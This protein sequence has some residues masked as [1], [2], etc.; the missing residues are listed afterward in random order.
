[1]ALRILH[2]FPPLQL[3]LSNGAGGCLINQ[4]FIQLSQPLV[5]KM[6]EKQNFQRLP[7]QHLSLNNIIHTA[8]LPR[9]K[10]SKCSQWEKKKLRSCFAN[11]FYFPRELRRGEE[12]EGKADGESSCNCFK[13]PCKHNNNILLRGKLSKCSKL[14]L[15]NSSVQTFLCF[16]SPC[17]ADKS[18]LECN[19][20]VC[21]V[22]HL[23]GMQSQ[24]DAMQII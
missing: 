2:F 10:T 18:L 3:E 19:K 4:R 16:V 15:H 11:T 22:M 1:M 20:T 12:N 24:S 9:K 5:G 8:D 14:N 6:R 13:Y 7:V 17:R 23:S 21:T